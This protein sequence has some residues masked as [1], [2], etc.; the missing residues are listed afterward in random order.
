MEPKNA[1]LDSSGQQLLSQNNIDSYLEIWIYSVQD[2]LKWWYV[3]MPIWHLRRLGRLSVVID[4]FLSITVL[5][6]N[7]FLPWHRDY[8]LIGYF[9][10][11]LVKLL[12]L[13]IAIAIYILAILIYIA[14]IMAWIALPIATMVFILISI[15]R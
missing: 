15:F 1:I 4:D 9:F 8:S 3:Q 6:K 7:F 5:I 12:Y 2:F 13:P 10:G 14:L 11:I